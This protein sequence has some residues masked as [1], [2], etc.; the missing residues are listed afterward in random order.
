MWQVLLPQRL[1]L[2]L[3]HGQAVRQNFSKIEII[4]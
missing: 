2:A 3:L 4:I 1:G